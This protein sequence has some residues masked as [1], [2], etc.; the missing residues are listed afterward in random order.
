[1]IVSVIAVHRMQPP[2]MDEVHMRAMLHHQ[3]L[4]ARMAV[5]VIVGGDAGDQFLSLGIGG[6]DVDHVFID[7]PVV[8]VVQVAIVEVV[9]MAR[10][11]DGLMAAV[12]AV[13]MGIVPAMQ[14]LMRKHRDSGKGKRK[15][16][17]S[18]GSIQGSVH[19]KPS[20]KL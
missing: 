12:S 3:V 19:E 14:H 6:A 8:L 7:M 9:D 17:R 11:S 4:L 5:G 10:M 15:H 13:S 1:M 16:R 18:G 20:K 2:V